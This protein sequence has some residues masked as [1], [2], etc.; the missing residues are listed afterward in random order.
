MNDSDDRTLF[1]RALLRRRHRPS[2]ANVR[3]T[4]HR[5]GSFTRPSGPSGRRTMARSHRAFAST[6]SYSWKSRYFESAYIRATWAHRLAVQPG[7][8]LGRR[9][10]VVHV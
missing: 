3:S 8:Q 5:I 2:H 7:E 10:G 6:H 9:L 4:V 1:S